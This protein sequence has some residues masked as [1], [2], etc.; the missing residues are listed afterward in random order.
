METNCLS[1]PQ[2]YDNKPLKKI[3]EFSVKS[4]GQKKNYTFDSILVMEDASQDLYVYFW[5]DL[6]KIKCTA[7]RYQE[8]A[9]KAFGEEKYFNLVRDTTFMMIDNLFYLNQAG[10]V[11]GDIKLGNVLAKKNGDQVEIRLCDYGQIL[12]ATHLNALTPQDRPFGTVVNLSP[13]TLSHLMRSTRDRHKD[14]IEEKNLRVLSTVLKNM[15]KDEEDFG[16]HTQHEDVYQ[17]GIMLL[18]L[19]S[20]TFLSQDRR[21]K[22]SYLIGL[23]NRYEKEQWENHKEDKEFLFEVWRDYLKELIEETP[24]FLHD[25]LKKMLE[26]D[27]KKRIEPEALRELIKPLTECSVKEKELK[28]WK[29]FIT[30][31]LRPKLTLKLTKYNKNK[32]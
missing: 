4:H 6:L 32:K 1:S 16:N 9:F 30:T 25:V 27:F 10:V 14:I 5:H 15:Y 13:E 11:H 31:D 23:Q 28:E 2:V 8:V 24:K 12:E 17:V 29:E 18:E 22:G 7:Q 20:F 19:S 26:P 21:W 3:F